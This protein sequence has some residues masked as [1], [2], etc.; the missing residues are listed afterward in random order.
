MAVPDVKAWNEP[1][2]C[3]PIMD[4]PAKNIQESG[5]EAK[6]ENKKRVLAPS[7]PSPRK[8]RHVEEPI[9]DPKTSTNLSIRRPELPPSLQPGASKLLQALK[10][11]SKDVSTSQS[12]ET[13]TASDVNLFAGGSS[14]TRDAESLTIIEKLE[15][16]PYEHTPP[17][18]DPTFNTFDPHSLIRLSARAASHE[19]LCEFL[20]GRYYLSP[21]VLYSI[22][23]PSKNRQGYDIPVDAEWVTI[24]V[25]AERGDIKL[26]NGSIQTTE[27]SEKDSQNQ[28]EAKTG[29]KKY[30]TIRLVDLGG[31]P[32]SDKTKSPRG[33][34]YLN[35][36]LFE[37]NSVTTSRETNSR[38]VERSYK[39]G[40]GGA[41]E[42]SSKFPEGTVIAICSPRVLRPYQAGRGSS[43]NPH[44]TMN[45]L[46]ISP[47]SASSILVIGKSRDLGHCVATRKDGKPCGSWCDKRLA[48][49][50]DFHLQ[51]A[52][53]SRRAGRA[54]FSVGTSGAPSNPG[55]KDPRGGYDP[56][57]KQGLIPVGAQAVPSSAQGLSGDTGAMYIIGTQVVRPT[58]GGGDE[59]VSENIGRGRQEKNKRR[60][61]RE[62]EEERLNSLLS[63]DGGLSSG[64]KA[65][66][67]ARASSGGS[68]YQALKAK[69][70]PTRVAFSAEAL[71][72]IGF[73]PTSSKQVASDADVKR[74]LEALEGL[75]R[76]S[77][78]I[79]LGKRPASK[80][81]ESAAALSDSE[82]V[83]VPPKTDEEDSELEFED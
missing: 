3:G 42:Q 78:K 61:E 39:G 30:T 11:K 14:S 12:N 60:K 33:D 65:L 81:P 59:F 29:P 57:K 53:Q 36:M 24:A 21:S 47:N 63:R 41:F 52:V 22:I 43:E 15:M 20:R 38:T 32:S 49:V 79:L 16:G 74:K 44:P 76:P 4:D 67:Q 27:S 62:E 73:D 45:V 83:S 35:M 23:R 13:A 8:R 75:Q 6:R 80:I 18:Q 5:D 7:T 40:S 25:V 56:S 46:G 17:S 69:D 50:C 19:D 28:T 68:D 82:A 31:G 54:E 2:P 58:K 10:A 37:A 26:Q 77:K 34:A 66:A 70:K 1:Q 48:A 64:A 71:K 9:I 55:R 72:R 51:Q